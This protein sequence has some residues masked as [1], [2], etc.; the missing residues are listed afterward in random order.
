MVTAVACYFSRQAISFRFAGSNPADVVFCSGLPS[1]G[2]QAG[3]GPNLRSR[4]LN[5]F[6]TPG[7]RFESFLVRIHCVRRTSRKPFSA[8]FVPVFDLFYDLPMRAA[9]GDEKQGLGIRRLRSTTTSTLSVKPPA[10]G[11]SNGVNAVTRPVPQDVL[12]EPKTP[13]AANLGLQ[14]NIPVN[15]KRFPPLAPPVVIRRV[16]APP[17]NRQ[18][19][20]A[21]PSAPVNIP[22]SQ[23][24]SVVSSFRSIRRADS[25]VNGS[26]HVTNGHTR[27][28]GATV[29]PKNSQLTPEDLSVN[30]GDSFPS[31][32]DESTDA[33]QRNTPIT[34]Q[35]SYTNSVPWSSRG[36][37]H[38][39][40]GESETLH[41]NGAGSMLQLMA[42]PNLPPSATGSV[43]E[44]DGN[45]A[46][47]F[48][49]ETEI[50][51]HDDVDEDL[52]DAIDAVQIAH[53]RKVLHFKRLLE[54]AHS[55]SASQLH[56]LQAELKLLRAT[57]DKERAINHQNEL[58]R[59]RDRLSL[60]LRKVG[61]PA[62]MHASH[63]PTTD[64]LS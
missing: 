46:T 35:P 22:E 5:N 9:A 1:G 18:S 48:G 44:G 43:W 50:M 20:P 54:S 47:S 60:S 17:P 64:T 59:D 26:P 28:R 32:L 31:Y 6:L 42:D 58:A 45:T 4:L 51:E 25:G 7:N 3:R 62:E 16:S 10:N 12:D 23:E 15:T 33:P 27:P 19:L 30:R 11:V 8:V 57:L 52:A 38:S 55:N 34:R 37:L 13:T 21:R 14:S 63:P 61:R 40:S 56:A 53:S 41:M 29:T 49:M 39:H 24:S 2:R 36:S